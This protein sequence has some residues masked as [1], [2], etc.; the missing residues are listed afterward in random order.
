VIGVTQMYNLYR[1]NSEWLSSNIGEWDILGVVFFVALVSLLNW[2]MVGIIT[3]Y[4]EQIKILKDKLAKK[5][6][7]LKMEVVK[8]TRDIIRVHSELEYSQKVLNKAYEKLTNV[9]QNR[10]LRTNILA[11]YSS[12]LY[13]VV[14]NMANP[15]MVLMHFIRNADFKDDESRQ[16]VETATTALSDMITSTR[17]SYKLETAIEV[18]PIAEV[19]KSSLDM[20]NG[21]I[22]K[23]EVEDESVI[24]D[25]L[26]VRGYK[27]KFIQIVLNL[28]DNAV[29]AGAKRI[30]ILT[31]VIGGKLYMQ[32]TDDGSGISTSQ[33]EKIFRLFYST[34]QSG[35]GVGLY[36]ARKFAQEDFNGDLRLKESA[37]GKTTFEVNISTLTECDEK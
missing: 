26:C 17:N 37:M 8:Q 14:H 12:L 27:S 28:I 6:K 13:S 18:F 11:H 10:F 23:N 32:V 5:N 31:E 34:K 4:L 24:Q 7:N 29:D 20:L 22:I 21:K 9:E 30:V 2:L 25:N 1:W 16:Q 33:S 3:T 19:V 35:S 15:M 36:I